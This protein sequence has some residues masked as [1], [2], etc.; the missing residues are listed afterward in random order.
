MIFVVSEQLSTLSLFTSALR[1]RLS[2]TVAGIDNGFMAIRM[3]DTN[4]IRTVILDLTSLSTAWLRA[5]A[6]A[7]PD[8]H[9]VAIGTG[10]IERAEL[11]T[12]MP[13]ATEFV[14]GPVDWDEVARRI[15]TAFVEAPDDG[16]SIAAAGLEGPLTLLAMSNKDAEVVVSAGGAIGRM[17]ISAGTI[18]S[19]ECDTTTG[20]EAVYAIMSW[21][22]P[23]VRTLPLREGSVSLDMSLPLAH[24]LHEAARRGDEIERLRDDRTVARILAELGTTPGFRCA[25]LVHVDTGSMLA[26]LGQAADTGNAVRAALATARAWAGEVTPRAD[27]QTRGSLSWSDSAIVAIIRV[28]HRFALSALSDEVMSADA[29]LDATNRAAS[30]IGE[31]IEQAIGGPAAG[32]VSAIAW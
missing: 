19:A 29:L 13:A 1:A 30:E 8:V 23:Y 10:K 11:A 27:G 14:A 32:P 3:I 2:E 9:C 15:E 31:H 17:Q 21:A 16:E 5:F 20:E 6:D 7:C 18:L 24:V 28:H 25:A 26:G 4:P 12:F 22:S